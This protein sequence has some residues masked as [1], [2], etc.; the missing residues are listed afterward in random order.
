MSATLETL[1]GAAQERASADARTCWAN[2]SD[3]GQLPFALAIFVS[4]FLVFQVQLLLG[5]VILPLFGGAPAVWTV[6]VFV[7][8]LLFLAGYGYSHGLATWLPI[9]KQ[10]IAHSVLLGISAIFIA[11]AAYIRSAPIGSGANWQPKPGDDPT[12]AIMKFLIAAIGLPFFLLSATSPL[13]QHW[14]AQAGPKRS[15]YRLYALSNA[16]SLL[17][18]LSYPS[19][20]EPHVGLGTQ[21]WAWAAGYGLFLGCYYFS[22]RSVVRSVAPSPPKPEFVRELRWDEVGPNERRVGWPLRLLWMGLAACASVLLL[23]TTN[24]VCQDI[25]VSPFLWVLQLSLYLLSFILCFESDRWYRRE[26]FYPAFAVA[27]AFVILVSLPSVMPS[28]M[29]QLAA[30]SAALFTGCMVCHGEAARTR[31]RAEL[32]TAFYLSIATGGA[33][34]GIA[35][36]LLAPR[37]FPNYWEYPLGV[38]GCIAVVLGV[39]MRE[40]SSWWHKGRASLALLIFAGAVLLAPPV[41]SPLWREAARLPRSASLYAAAVLIGAAAL[42]YAME[43][44]PPRTTPAPILVRNASRVVLALLTAGLLIPQKAA[45][46]H[47]IA[48]SR[49][50]YGVLSVVSVEQENYL[51]LQ[52]GGTI[53]GFQYRDARRARLA[54]GYYGPFS[55]ANIVI[56]NWPQHPMRVGLVGMGVGTLAALAH[57]GDVFRFYEINPDVYKLSAPATAG[58]QPYFTYL[59]DSPGRIEVV[60]G[61]ARLSLEGEAN[62]GDFQKFDV[63]VLDAFSSDAIPMHLL[64]R[65]AFQVYAKHL[66]GPASVIAVHISNQTLDLRPVLAGI[67]RDFGLHAVRI[68]LLGAGPFSQSDWILLSRDTASLSGKEILSGSEPFPADT[69]PISWTD[70]YCNLLKVMRWND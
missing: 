27:V 2:G 29:M 15:P 38:L 34:G 65:E 14:F 12:W 62:R 24:L 41:L 13:M 35:V 51:A 36:S 20:V 33:L 26:V 57:A 3:A 28:F 52:Y 22:A 17:G 49:S 55:G 63:L 18:L 9:R 37:I 42:R 70:D 40:G 45:L 46:Y 4:A 21:R 32:L 25:P 68:D 8:Q 54:T 59:R 61:D 43:R 48:S 60:P 50:F 19:L 47:V 6:C 30:Y 5:K 44:R 58:Q 39:S 16:G 23:A 66:R 31:P 10:V 53:H 64:T 67:G 11:L 56:R 7:F 69:Q 1:P